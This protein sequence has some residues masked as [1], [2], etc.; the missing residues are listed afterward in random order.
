MQIALRTFVS[1]DEEAFRLLN[2]AWIGQYFGL[3]DADHKILGDPVVY[4]LAPGGQIYMALDGG[5]RVGTCAL[6]KMSE[7]E[8]EVAKMAVTDE[9]RGKGIGRQLLAFVIADALRMGAR[10]L[11]IESN[12]P[13]KNA[14]HLYE[15][16]GFRH[17]S[18]GEAQPHFARGDVFMELLLEPPS[19]QAAE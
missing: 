3:E 6:I 5:K 12:S 9:L 2:E 17:L 8:F 11:Y 10:R 7:G 15:A 1:G 16:L 14:I 4:I 13:L 19:A 18:H